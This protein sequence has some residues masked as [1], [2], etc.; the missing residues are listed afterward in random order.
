MEQVREKLTVAGL[1]VLREEGFAAFTQPRVCRQA[2]VRQS[3]LTYY[4]PT[5]TDLLVAVAERAVADRLAVIA[6]SVDESIRAPHTAAAAVAQAIA[7]TR[8][9]RAFLAL[10]EAADHEPRVRAA[11]RQLTDGV[12][13]RAEAL[14]IQ[15]GIE[16]TDTAI[17]LV[18]SLTV[19]IAV[20][21][22]ARGEKVETHATRM[23]SLAFELLLSQQP[24]ERPAP[25]R[26]KKTKVN[27]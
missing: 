20:L 17:R 27:P 8:G 21:G 15:L 1:Q 7:S 5:R 10:A 12:A 9:N 16:P 26:S 13:K 3:H 2:G 18:H 6:A 11:F 4:F 23:L 22:V 14:L 19:G 24:L 25:L